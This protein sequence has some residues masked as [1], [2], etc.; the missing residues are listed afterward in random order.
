MLLAIALL[1][2]PAAGASADGPVGQDPSSNFSPG[3][4]PPQCDTDPN[5]TVCVESAVTYL[6]AARANLGQG[7]YLLPSDFVSLTPAEQ[8]FVLTNLDRTRYGLPPVPGMTAALNRDASAGIPTDGD[9]R[10]SGSSYI[11][12][13]SNWAGG[14]PNMPL[15][16]EAWMYDDGPGSGNL[17]CPRTGASGCWG[18]RHDVLWS[19]TGGGALAAGAASGK[20]SGGITG[21][22][23]LLAEGDRS[24]RPAYT[25][26]WAQA[27]AAG[28]GGPVGSGSSGSSGSSRTPSAGAR[29]HPKVRIRS[30]RV[31]GHR[32]SVTI[33]APRGQRLRC[34]MAR[35]SGRSWRAY[36]LSACTRSFTITNVPS[37]RWRLRVSAKAGSATRYFLVTG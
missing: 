33:A 1:C 5:G 25:Y 10:A 28:A 3:L 4:L 21:Y 36:R 2:L 27:V 12:Y 16:Y 6:N 24:Y 32:V 26:T 15:A 22:T 35:R 8:A 23:L 37:G 13:T 7:P 20:D 18:H 34:S 30:V 31:R 19:F 17:D 29:R 11:A 14:Y 9:A